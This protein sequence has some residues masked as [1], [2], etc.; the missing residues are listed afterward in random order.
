MQKNRVMLRQVVF[1]GPVR[2]AGEMSRRLRGKAKMG[3]GKTMS[4][5]KMQDM[6]EYIASLKKQN[7]ALYR[8]V[9]D[10]LAVKVDY[11]TALRYYADDNNYAARNIQMLDR[12]RKA[13]DALNGYYS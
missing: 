5:E 7:T 10:L 9:L 13:K 4:A 6:A 11:E 3:E 2:K 1:Q 8:Q 12:G